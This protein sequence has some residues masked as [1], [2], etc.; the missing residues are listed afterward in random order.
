MPLVLKSLKI[1]KSENSSKLWF[2]PIKGHSLKMVHRSSLV[3]PRTI[4]EIG[5]PI[6]ILQPVLPA[7]S[8]FELLDVPNLL[9]I[10]FSSV[11]P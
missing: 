11:I 8:I 6:C 4:F 3:G 10:R 5:I 9:K 7:H 2:R 1:N